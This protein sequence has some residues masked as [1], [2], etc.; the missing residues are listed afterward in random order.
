V[1]ATDEFFNSFVFSA[2]RAFV[3]GSL[4]V[5]PCRE[6]RN[7]LM[8]ILIVKMSAIGDVIHTLPALNAVRAH[9]PEARI[10]WL[11]EEAAAP[12]VLGHKALD[13][14]LI[15]RRKTW[16]SSLPTLR[17]FDAAQQILHFIGALRDTA[18]DVI[19]DFQGLLKSGVLIGLARGKRK[20]GFDRGM[21]HAEES[22][23]FLN[24]RVAPVG[25]EI[26]A[27]TRSMLLL[28]AALGIVSDEVVYDL[29]L[30]DTDR[31]AAK[32]LLSAAVNRGNG[33][34]VAV[35]PAA[36]WETKLWENC[37]FSQ[38]CDILIRRYNARIVLTGDMSDAPMVL[39]IQSGMQER[40]INLAGKTTL[41]TLAAVFEMVDYVISTDTGPMHLAAAAGAPVAALFGPTAPWRTGP[42]GSG[43][44]VVRAQLDCSP[45]FKRTCNTIQ[46]MKAITVNEVLEAVEELGLI[47]S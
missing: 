35:H 46:C 27:L 9:F 43:H 41:K 4:A 22:H 23:L 10:T 34:L 24:E 7:A 40:A 8:N 13:R 31:H 12:L 47:R 1:D 44:R 38:L 19:L 39:E 5:D 21:E 42:F 11:V 17:G 25:M 36:K 2:L 16:V 20:I 26:H 6:L 28:E 37:R 45:C 14:V 33:P 18:Y 30:R 3:V 29:P 15:S 32:R